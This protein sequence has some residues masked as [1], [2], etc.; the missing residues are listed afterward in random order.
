MTL[1]KDC[2]RDAL[3]L[4]KGSVWSSFHNLI[5]ECRL[6]IPVLHSPVLQGALRKDLALEPITPIDDDEH[7]RPNDYQ[8]CNGKHKLYT[9]AP[10]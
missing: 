2:L 6:L 10:L 7:N 3:L 9:A 5:Q 4:R 1:R 8:D